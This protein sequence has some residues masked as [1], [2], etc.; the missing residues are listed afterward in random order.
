MNAHLLIVDDE[1]DIRDML[2]RH[3]RYLGYEV[4]TAKDG[5]DALETLKERKFDIVVSDIAMPNLDGTQLLKRIRTDY[6]MVRT[7]MITA[8]VTLDNALACIRYGADACVFKPL[9]NLEELEQA[10]SASLARI[11]YWHGILKQLRG[12]ENE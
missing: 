11:C 3:F 10:V 7:I 2:C 5:L 8:Y 9:T 6:P 12:L 1:Q 4:A